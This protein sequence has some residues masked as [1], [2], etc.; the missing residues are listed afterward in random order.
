MGRETNGEE[1]RRGEE[2]K[3]RG[4][5]IK[6]GKGSRGWGRRRRW[7]RW[8]QGSLPDVSILLLSCVLTFIGLC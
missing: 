3:Q 2:R 8:W 5:G 1:K 4:E 7:R 6:R